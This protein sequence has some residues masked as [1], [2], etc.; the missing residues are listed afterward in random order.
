M[1]NLLA[2]FPP[3]TAM[4]KLLKV[5]VRSL[6]AAC[7]VDGKRWSQKPPKVQTFVFW[8]EAC[9][10]PHRK[11]QVHTNFRTPAAQCRLPVSMTDLNQG[12]QG[13]FGC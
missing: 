2:S 4:T 8:R 12:C 10:A 9:A 5:A 11:T 13:F 7:L 1:S 3:F 6:A